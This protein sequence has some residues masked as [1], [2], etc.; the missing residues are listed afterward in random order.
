MVYLSILGALKNGRELEHALGKEVE[1]ESFLPKT[2]LDSL[3]LHKICLVF[4]KYFSE[5]LDFVFICYFLQYKFSSLFRIKFF[6]KEYIMFEQ[7]MP[8]PNGNKR[9]GINIPSLGQ[10]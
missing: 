9:K 1:R 6:S 7:S 10:Q 8:L 2:K 5:F 4:P 3:P